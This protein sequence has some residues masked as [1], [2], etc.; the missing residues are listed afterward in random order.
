[1]TVMGRVVQYGSPAKFPQSDDPT[2]SAPSRL[3]RLDIA[4]F[5]RNRPSAAGAEPIGRREPQMDYTE[6]GPVRNAGGSESY[7]A[8]NKRRSRVGNF[9]KKGWK[10]NELGSGGVN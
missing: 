8:Q 6:G 5:E 9:G 1:M 7:N 2:A 4:G 3:S 10:K